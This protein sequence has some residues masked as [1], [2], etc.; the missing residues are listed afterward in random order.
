MKTKRFLFAVFTFALVFNGCMGP[1]Q[2]YQTYKNEQRLRYGQDRTYR[3]FS[4]L[5][6]DGLSMEAKGETT[7]TINVPL[8]QLSQTQI[9]DDVKTIADFS[10][11]AIGAGLIGY[12]I[13]QVGSNNQSTPSVQKTE[14]A[15]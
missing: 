1:G 15:Q 6:K 2:R 11:W 9:P 14:A 4:I 10:K 5:A 13:H 3:P 12:G 8:E 7:L